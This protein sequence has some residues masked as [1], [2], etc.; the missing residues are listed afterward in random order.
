MWNFTQKFIDSVGVD[1]GKKRNR[2]QCFIAIFFAVNVFCYVGFTL[3]SL[4]FYL[5][6]S[7]YC[8]KCENGIKFNGSIDGAM[9][10]HV[11]CYVQ[12]QSIR[13]TWMKNTQRT[14]NRKIALKSLLGS[15]FGLVRLRCVALSSVSLNVLDRSHVKCVACFYWYPT[16][17]LIIYG[18]LCSCIFYQSISVCERMMEKKACSLS[19]QKLITETFFGALLSPPSPSHHLLSLWVKSSNT[20]LVS[21][22]IFLRQSMMQSGRCSV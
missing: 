19:C 3:Q 16:L 17:L 10:W 12:H 5:H 21:A 11:A 6:A 20:F 8:I 18:I 9:S 15:G 14:D 22:N 1:C 2:I 13:W 4:E 7:M